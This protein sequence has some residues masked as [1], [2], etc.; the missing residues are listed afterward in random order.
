M[1]LKNRFISGGRS[2]KPGK[3]PSESSSEFALGE[4]I[5]RTRMLTMPDADVVLAASYLTPIDRRY[6]SESTVSS[7]LGAPTSAEQGDATVRWRDCQD[8]ATARNSMP[9][10]PFQPTRAKKKSRLEGSGGLPGGSK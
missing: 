9:P 8:C 10:F 3:G 5:S 1:F 6:N 4:T 7:T 2:P